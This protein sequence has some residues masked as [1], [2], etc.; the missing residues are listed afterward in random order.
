MITVEAS[1]SCSRVVGGM[2]SELLK[3]NGKERL[4]DNAGPD[5][6]GEREEEGRSIVQR[7]R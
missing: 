1:P 7:Q 3:R 6:G 5:S 4:R 2:I